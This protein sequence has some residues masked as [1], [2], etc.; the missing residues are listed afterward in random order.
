MQLKTKGRKKVKK[1]LIYIT[2]KK[3]GASLRNLA[4]YKMAVLKILLKL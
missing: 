3:V 2:V 4:K 1:V